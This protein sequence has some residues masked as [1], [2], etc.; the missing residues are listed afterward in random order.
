MWVACVSCPTQVL[1]AKRVVNKARG[2]RV[3]GKL[4]AVRLGKGPFGQGAIWAR[5]HLWT[6]PH[7]FPAN[8]TGRLNRCLGLGDVRKEFRYIRL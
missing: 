2:G 1:L 3:P 8:R 7:V 4:V 6:L 5:G